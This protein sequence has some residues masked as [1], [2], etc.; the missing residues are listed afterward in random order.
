MYKITD[1]PIHIILAESLNSLTS[2]ECD[3]TEKSDFRYYKPDDLLTKLTQLL[4]CDK[5]KIYDFKTFVH[6]ET[7][8]IHN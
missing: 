1:D 2:L 5:Y 6:R 8:E 3:G 4:T 7:F